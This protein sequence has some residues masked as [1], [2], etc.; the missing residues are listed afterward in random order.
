MVGLHDVMTAGAT[1]QARASGVAVRASIVAAVVAVALL[2]AH[3]ACAAGPL[4]SAIT[5]TNAVASDRVDG[6]AAPG[7]GALAD[8]E[9]GPP[10]DGELQ[11]YGCLISGAVATGLTWFAG[12]NQMIMVVAGGTLAPTSTVGLAVAITG[13]VFAS[14]CA[15]GALGTPAILRLWHLYYDG[16]H[17]KTAP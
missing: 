7:A 12:T 1:A 17:V 13:T 2:V 10:S 4:Q 16:K 15:V 8:D 6:P 11:G 5:A 14:V 3:P 9:L